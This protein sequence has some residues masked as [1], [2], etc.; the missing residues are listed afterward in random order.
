MN[1]VNFDD[2]NRLILASAGVP[3][4]GSLGPALKEISPDQFRRGYIAA[5][6]AADSPANRRIAQPVPPEG[7]G[8]SASLCTTPDDDSPGEDSREVQKV[9]PDRS[10]A[11]V[12]DWAA[13]LASEAERFGGPAG[14]VPPPDFR[15]AAAADYHRGPLTED[16]EAPSPG[17]RPGN[18][19]V[20]PVT[21]SGHERYEAGAAAYAGN[22]QRATAQHVMPSQQCVSQPAPAQWSPPPDLGASNVPQ[23]RAAGATRKAPGE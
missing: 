9:S 22:Q 6:H 2:V 10:R 5:G 13:A 3:E 23:P 4:G 15:Q 8:R 12:V 19:P 16:H 21:G 20:S 17:D 11:D 18:S 7:G 14:P 1:E